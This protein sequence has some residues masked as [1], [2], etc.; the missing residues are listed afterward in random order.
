MSHVYGKSTAINGVFIAR[1]YEDL[2]TSRSNSY[3]TLGR[4][5]PWDDS[6]PEEVP[7]V[8]D[9]IETQADAFRHMAI[10]K[11]IASS[12]V[13]LVVPDNYWVSG[14]IYDQFN[15]EDDMYSH[16]ESTL[17]TGYID[18][19]A[20][21]NTIS[22]NI[23]STTVFTNELVNGDIIEFDGVSEDEIKVRRQVIDVL[24]DGNVTINT[25]VDVDYTNVSI[26]KIENS[27]PRYAKAFYVRNSYDQ[28]F[29]CIFNNGGA[30]STV[31]PVLRPEYFS[32]N[33]LV[34]D[35][36]DG[37][38][39]RYLYTIPSG[40]KE[41]FYYTDREGVRWIPVVTD[42][43][44]ALTTVDGAVELIKVVD[45]GSGYNA[46]NPNS[47]ADIIT[48]TGDGTGA[49]YTANVIIDTSINESTIQGVLTANAGI[50]YS[51]A[52][53]TANTAEGG[54]G[55][56]FKA[57]I[58]PPGGFGADPANDLGA[59]YLAIS[60]EFLDDVS[61]L[62]PATSAAGSVK[63]RQIG[64]LSNPQ[65]ANGTYINTSVFS[66]AFNV[67]IPSISITG[68]GNFVGYTFV[69]NNGTWDVISYDQA[70]ST[71]LL[72]NPKGEL[73]STDA[74]NDEFEIQTPFTGTVKV[75]SS[76]NEIIYDPLIARSGEMLYLENFDPVTR[77]NDQVEQ[78]KIILKF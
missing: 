55:A 33:K 26:Y 61:G 8:V 76:V 25:S 74:D 16:D 24:D 13:N 50:S 29:I 43:I 35:S 60:V 59:K 2:L 48:I 38:I 51:Y 5:S 11:K 3:V 63:F 57:L 52:D 58:S 72:N 36:A 27:Y 15:S 23:Y 77:E 1:A 41:K 28:V 73:V 69:H 68:V 66:P 53:V 39:W 70:T 19:T 37:Y 32:F 10:M 71:L 46:N 65:Y 34:A 78:I 44:V 40:L 47:S 64:V 42:N 20:D 6:Q 21:S 17:I 49:V 12:D 31:E 54:S 67:S 14:T 22:N 62:F 45:G 75:V 30:A 7:L 9:T 4:V 56:E 18:Y